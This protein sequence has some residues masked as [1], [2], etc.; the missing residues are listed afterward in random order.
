MDSPLARISPFCSLPILSLPGQAKLKVWA[1]APAG[2]FAIVAMVVSLLVGDGLDLFEGS[3]PLLDLDEARLP[4]VLHPFTQ[5]LVGQVDRG[6]VLHDDAFHL[7]G[8]GHHL[9]DAYPAF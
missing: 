9:V 2:F 1:S 7:L 6:A 8:N 4:Q 3:Q 5:C